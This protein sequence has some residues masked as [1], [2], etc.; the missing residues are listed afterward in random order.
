MSHFAKINSSNIIT[1]VIVAEKDFINSGAVGDEFLWIQTS[2]SGSFRK[3]Y[4]VVGGAYDKTNDVFVQPKPFPSWTLDDSHDWQP[5][6]TYPDDGQ[7][8]VWDEDTTAWV[9]IIGDMNE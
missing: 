3:N 4:A 5:P 2:Y 8:Y 7:N 9:E 1:E 6:T